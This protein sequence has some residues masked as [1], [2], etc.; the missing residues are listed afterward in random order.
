MKVVAEGGGPVEDVT[1]KVGHLL[2]NAIDGNYPMGFVT[3][4]T[5]EYG[6]ATLEIRVQDSNWFSKTQH[7]R[8]DVE[9]LTEKKQ[10]ATSYV[11]D[12]PLRV[13]GYTGSPDVNGDYFPILDSSNNID[14]SCNGM[15]RYECTD[16]SP[17]AYLWLSSDGTTS[18][19]IINEQ[20][21]CS[22]SGVVTGTG[23]LADPTSADWGSVE[24]VALMDHDFSP[25]SEVMAVRHLGEAIFEFTD[26][27]SVV[28]SGTVS[29]AGFHAAYFAEGCPHKK[30]QYLADSFAVSGSTNQAQDGTYQRNGMCE[31]LPSYKCDDCSGDQYI[32]YYPRDQRWYIGSGGCGSAS[33]EI[34]VADTNADLE[35]VSGSWEEW[36][37]SKFASQAAI[38]V[39]TVKYFV[40]SGSTNHASAHGTWSLATCGA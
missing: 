30:F 8:V 7:F 5:D 16:C 28:V 27:T 38:S 31:S 25:A 10:T 15:P 36:D 19:W 37:G 17:V 2:T 33:A 14:T 20:S 29:H 26:M 12:H 21:G 18:D 39:T 32:W 3:A 1:V 11:Q 4:Q 6:E 40:V 35:A 24:V 22:G 13:S 23:S 9:K 34:R